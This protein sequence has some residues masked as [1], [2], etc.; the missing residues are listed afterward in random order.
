MKKNNWL[1]FDNL[2]LVILI[3]VLLSH[4]LNLFSPVLDKWFLIII[5]FIA[6]LPVVLKAF[7]LLLKNKKF[8]I[9]LLAAVALIFSLLAQE[10]VSVIFISLMLTSA[11]ILA[12]YTK[13]RSRH[14]IQSL[15]KL[16]PQKAKIEKEDKLIEVPINTLKKGD[17]VVVDLGERIPVDGVVEKGEASVDQ[18]SLTGESIPVAK[19]KG[20]SVFS[21]TIV[22]SG[23]LIIRTEKIGKETVFEKIINLVE[24]SQVNKA[25]IQ[26]VSEKFTSWY[27]FITLVGSIIL[28]SISR[29]LSLVLSVLLVT[30][31][32]DI[33]V[34]I[35][36]AFLAAIGQAAK[37][38]VIVKGSNFLEGLAKTKV[39]FVDKT[40]TL[41]RG[42]LKVEE[43]FAFNNLKQDEVLKL[44][45]IASL[46]SNHP[47]A[48]AIVKK[49]KEIGLILSEPT[50]FEEIPGKGT[51]AFYENK[52]IITGKQSFFQELGIK[53]SDEE[54]KIIKRE[55]EKGLNITLIGYDDKLLGFIGLIDALRP[56][57]KETIAE[58]KKIG[59]E[60]IIM[61][62]GDNEK[63][64]KRIAEEANI[65]EW[66]AN[67]LPEDKLKY[68]KKYLSQQYKL[69]MV[70]DGVNDAAALSLAD[71]GI[72]MGAI[73]SDAAIEAADVA[74][75]KD[76]FSKVPEIIK[77]A[78]FTL[79]ISRQDFLIWG[80]VNAIGLLLVFNHILTPVSAS[81]YNFATD[82]IPLINSL[83]LF[84]LKLGFSQH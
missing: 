64:A 60:K 42:K 25:E 75:M 38:G 47:A 18:S 50:K 34:A 46:F 32:D 43:A 24:E 53:I 65:K 29:N 79:K 23:N 80:V 28:Y 6:T 17:L 84:G 33:A 67:L 12:A 76:D 44:A 45:G 61:L 2:L 55:K 5:S 40:G 39:M 81:A 63:I 70:G 66:H 69:A 13:A 73:G 71:I 9:D 26:S 37:Q 49:A 3:V 78:K 8:S 10:W 82:F 30:C 14:A 16:K 4:Y 36:L 57:I 52:K 62:T 27:I 20:D 51:R 68:L 11:R 31:A 83:R 56:K 21:S 22:V 59:I 15:L 72:A 74:L 35:P 19:T 1:N 41:T 48:K 54:Q 58:L 77:L 7:W